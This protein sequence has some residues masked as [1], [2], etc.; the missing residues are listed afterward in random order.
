M[1]RILERVFVA[2]IVIGAVVCLGGVGDMEQ[3]REVTCGMGRIFG[4][5]AISGAGL[6]ALNWIRR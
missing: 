5:G 2:V 3:S 1:R 6:L 4:G